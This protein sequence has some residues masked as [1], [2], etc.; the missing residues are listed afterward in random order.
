[1]KFPQTQKVFNQIA[2]IKSLQ[3]FI[4]FS[5]CAQIGT[6][7]DFN[8]FRLNT[9]AYISQGIKEMRE[10]I[11]H[12]IVSSDALTNHL[13]HRQLTEFVNL[14]TTNEFEK[15][16]RNIKQFNLLIKPKSKSVKIKNTIDFKLDNSKAISKEIVTLNNDLM[17]I[18]YK[19]SLKSEFLTATDELTNYYLGFVN[20]LQDGLIDS[21]KDLLPVLKTK[22]SA[23]LL[24]NLNINEHELQETAEK[25]MKPV[26]E[27][28]GLSEKAIT[29]ASI[30]P[31]TQY[32]MKTVA[33]LFNYLK[34]KNLIKNQ[35][36][37]IHLSEMIEILTGHSSNSIRQKAFTNINDIKKEN[38][39]KKGVSEIIWTNLD[40]VRELLM[41]IIEDIDKFKKD[42]SDR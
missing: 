7:D 31:K 36:P 23:N 1:M 20:E 33:I 42:N 11:E 29:S 35:I 27:N 2:Y 3:Y 37:I 40:P 34:E 28:L 21:Y 22:S 13:I 41:S 9:I 25:I 38:I 24:L 19:G 4:E 10:E 14:N 18:T 17:S 15:I 32:S 6:S 39:K 5:Q 26:I 12:I 30:L 16:K 8:T